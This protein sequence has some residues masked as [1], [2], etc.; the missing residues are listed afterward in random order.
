MTELTQACADLRAWLPEAAVL[1]TQ[2]DT[3]PAIGRTAPHSTRYLYIEAAMT[4]R[5]PFPAAIASAER[6]LSHYP[7][8]E[9]H[10]IRIHDAR[11]A[12]I[13]PLPLPPA[14]ALK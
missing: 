10:L 4:G 12:G 14:A 3:Q 7:L 8:A 5:I 11:E 2:P 1:I 13:Y 9:V 6:G